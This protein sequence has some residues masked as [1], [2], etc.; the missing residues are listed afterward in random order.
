[1]AF[2]FPF[3]KLLWD[4]STN[5]YRHHPMYTSTAKELLTMMDDNLFAA[6]HFLL[7]VI[8]HY[9]IPEKI[10]S[11]PLLILDNLI[12]ASPTNFCLLL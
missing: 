8:N 9:R 1:M 2:S 3:F 10:Q 12:V 5:S 11:S 7:V 4:R 6:V